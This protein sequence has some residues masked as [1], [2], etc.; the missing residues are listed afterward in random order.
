MALGTILTIIIYLLAIFIIFKVVKK[1]AKAVIYAA[2][3]TL[4]L[5]LI[6]GLFV[7]KDIID[8]RKSFTEQGTVVLLEDKGNILAGYTMKPSPKFLTADKIAEYNA[9][10][11]DKEYDKIRN[12]GY[13]LMIIKIELVS[14]LKAEKISIGAVSIKKET[15]ISVLKSDRPFEL[16]NRA[17]TEDEGFPSAEFD[18]RLNDNLKLKAALLGT[19]VDN[20]LLG[21]KNAINFFSEYKK[22]NIIIYPETALFKFAKLFPLGMIKS[23]AKKAFA[24]AKEITGGIYLKI[25]EAYSANA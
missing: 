22:G 24:E 5:L 10:L 18:A 12:E 17:L 19:I 21:A 2:S 8:F 3:I 23:V 7:A 11:E 9:Y 15:M 13:K 1:I 20:E 25:E 14:G 16:F 6:F 4:L